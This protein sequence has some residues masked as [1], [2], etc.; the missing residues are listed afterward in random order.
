MHSQPMYV[1]PLPHAHVSTSVFSGSKQQIES[2]ERMI[3]NKLGSGTMDTSGG[4]SLQGIRATGL[5]PRSFG[6]GAFTSHGRS[7]KSRS[8]GRSVAGLAPSIFW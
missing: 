7:Q 1:H 8:L 2:G 3:L 4:L 5:A 6:R